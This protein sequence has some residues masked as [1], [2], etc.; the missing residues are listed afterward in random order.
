MTTR[1]TRTSLLWIQPRLFI[2]VGVRLVFRLQ[3]STYCNSCHGFIWIPIW[4]FYYSMERSR[5]LLWDGSSPM[6]IP[7]QSW[8]QSLILYRDAFIH[9]SKNRLLPNN[10][11]MIRNYGEDKE[12]L[13]ERH[14]GAKEQQRWPSQVG[15][16]I[17]VELESNSDSRNSWHQNHRLDHIPTLFWT[18][19]YGWKAKRIIFPMELVTHPN[20][21]WVHR[22]CWNNE[23]HRICHGAVLP[24]LGPIGYVSSWAQ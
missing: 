16:P 11:M 5:S 6:W 1:L 7:Y 4:V 14:G 9:D 2:G 8:S 17:Q 20:S 18:F 10:V 21:F 23:A 13:K 24:Y 15:V 19:L 3:E 12:G 22:K